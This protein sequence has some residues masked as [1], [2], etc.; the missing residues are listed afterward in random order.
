MLNK[1]E[2]CGVNTAKLTVLKN[3]E[4]ME[5]LRQTKEGNK[6][7]RE[8]LISGNLR[9]VLSV[10]QKFSSRGENVDDLFQVGCIG[11]IKAIDNFDIT[12][13]VRFSTYGVPMNVPR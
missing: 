10:I 11:L 9:L 12:Q 5:L 2:I 7:A 1:V 4:T 6:E 8:K 3:D 13:P